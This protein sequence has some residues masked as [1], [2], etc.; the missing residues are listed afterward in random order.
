MTSDIITQLEAAT[1]ADQSTT[2]MDAVEYAYT[3]GW[4]TKTVHQKAVLFVVAGAFLDAARTL[5]PEGWDWRVGESDAPDTGIP[6]NHAVLRDWGEPDE[7]YIPTYAP[8]PALALSIACIKA[9][10]QK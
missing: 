10:G 5:V 7:I 3:R 1:E 6:K 8:T 2:L 4:I 9:W